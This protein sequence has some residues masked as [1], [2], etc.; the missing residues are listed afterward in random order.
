MLKTYLKTNHQSTCLWILSVVN[1]SVKQK[2][3]VTATVAAYFW[4]IASIFRKSKGI[5]SRK[6]NSESRECLCFSQQ[7]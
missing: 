2:I 4:V 5:H 1:A 6:V 7:S 3:T